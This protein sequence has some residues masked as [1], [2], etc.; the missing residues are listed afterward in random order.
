MSLL[1]DL[2]EEYPAAKM[3]YNFLIALPSPPFDGHVILAARRDDPEWGVLP[4]HLMHLRVPSLLLFGEMNVSFEGA[5]FDRKAQVLVEKANEPMKT[6]V[7][8]FISA[9]DEG[10]RTVNRL[11]FWIGVQ[12]GCNVGIVLPQIGAGRS[13]I[14]G[15]LS[16]IAMVQ[17]PDGSR[18]HHDVARSKPAFKD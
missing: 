13:N 6:V 7:R 16:G 1:A 10:I 3:I 11:C 12:Q 8:E 17:V 5:G 9:I 18:Q 15:E 4:R 14:N 2:D